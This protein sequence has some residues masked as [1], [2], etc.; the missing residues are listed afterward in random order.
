LTNQC[1][2]GLVWQ[3]LS[4]V[5]IYYYFIPPP[6]SGISP[7]KSNRSHIL[8]N[9]LCLAH[10]PYISPA[11]LSHIHQNSLTLLDIRCLWSCRCF[12]PSNIL[13]ASILAHLKQAE[14]SKVIHVLMSHA[15]IIIIVRR[16]VCMRYGNLFCNTWTEPIY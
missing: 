1:I 16:Y 15:I 8:S 4:F 3:T 12:T 13:V 9:P 5:I 7:K 6:F 11:N 2:R 14:V 10:V